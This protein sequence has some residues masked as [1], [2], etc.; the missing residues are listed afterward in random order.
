MQ[1]QR[2]SRILAL[3]FATCQLQVDYDELYKW[4]E[5]LIVRRIR[6]LHSYFLHYHTRFLDGA[7]KEWLTVTKIDTPSIVFAITA[8]WRASL[9]KYARYII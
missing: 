1:P 2:L 8:S 4:L 7:G 3:A 5:H 6:T 9:F